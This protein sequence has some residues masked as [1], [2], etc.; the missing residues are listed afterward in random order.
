MERR[1][2]G[3][4][5]HD[6]GV[7]GLGAWQIGGGWGSVDSQDAR[8]VLHAAVDAGMSFIDTADVYG[9][10]RSEQLIDRKSVV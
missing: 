2:L 6:I 3:K 9:D 7:V 8:D 10:G 5:G 1:R 4:T